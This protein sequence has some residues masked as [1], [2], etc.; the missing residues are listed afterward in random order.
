M[1]KYQEPNQYL[2]FIFNDFKGKDKLVELIATQVSAFTDNNTNLKFNYDDNCVIMHFQSEFSF[3]V[4]RDH[5]HII[6]EK[7][8]SQYFLMETPKKLYAFMPP[9]L[10]LNL[11]D[12]DEK[13]NT[14]GKNKSKIN[15]II[16][17]F[18]IGFT[19]SFNSDLFS[20]E[21]MN[22]IFNESMFYEDFSHY[23]P[24]T[25]DEILEKIAKNGLN[26]LTEEEKQILDEYSKN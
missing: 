3:Y 5:V 18:I 15:D 14:A 1:S 16:D 2:L 19:S 11:F 9:D 20:Q 24:P 4:I 21:N 17:N 25:I 12:L 23:K 13:N 22:K 8:V 10:K 6:L 26:S 7:V